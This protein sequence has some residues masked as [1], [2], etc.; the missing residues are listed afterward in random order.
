MRLQKFPKYLLGQTFLLILCTGLVSGLAQEKERSLDSVAGVLLGTWRGEG[1]GP[2]GEIFTSELQF[3]WTLNKQFLKAENTIETGGK[4]MLFATTYYGWQPVMKKIVFW[5][6][7]RQGTINE[8]TAIF[9]GKTLT[10]QWRSF[11]Q[12]GAIKD[13]R[14]TLTAEGKKQLLF[15]IHGGDQVQGQTVR[16]HK[17]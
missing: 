5:S 9:D 16:Y 17:R 13:W 7:D 2:G 12:N 3:S 6:F 4:K 8:G 10:H 14:S 1:Q 15:T 11:S